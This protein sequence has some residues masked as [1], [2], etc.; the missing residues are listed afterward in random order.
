MN[1]T[2]LGR[3]LARGPDSGS[4]ELEAT[5]AGA[6]SAV[7]ESGGNGSCSATSD[8]PTTLSREVE[9]TRTLSGWVTPS[10][11]VE[12]ARVRSGPFSDEGSGTGGELAIEFVDTGGAARSWVLL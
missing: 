11:G 1:G 2:A 10:F 3:E 4:G 5:F 12:S 7:R 8:F 9:S 6:K